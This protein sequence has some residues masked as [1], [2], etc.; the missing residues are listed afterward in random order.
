MSQDR[1]NVYAGKAAQEYE[2]TLPTKIQDKNIAKKGL[3]KGKI[4][5]HFHFSDI[6]AV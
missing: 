6:T 3:T 1:I 4:M 2:L 5:L